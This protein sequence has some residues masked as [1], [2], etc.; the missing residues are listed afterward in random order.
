MRGI[1]GSATG[2]GGDGGEERRLRDA[3]AYFLA[4]HVAAGVDQRGL[5]VYAMQERMGLGFCPVTD[6]EACDKQDGHGGKDR[7]AVPGRTSHLAQGDGERRGDEK[8]QFDFNE[9]AEGRGI[10][11]GVPT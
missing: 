10:L 2:I 7:P 4:F 11:E 3:E 9:V 6:E 8:D 1:D 5:L